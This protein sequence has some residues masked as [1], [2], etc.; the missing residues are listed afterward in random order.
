MSNKIL[1]FK[2]VDGSDIVSEVEGTTKSTFLLINPMLMRSELLVENGVRSVCYLCPWIPV[3]VVK[4]QNIEI[5]KEKVLFYKEVIEEITEIY[6]EFVDEERQRER[7][8]QQQQKI[9]A[10]KREETKDSEDGESRNVIY[11]NSINDTKH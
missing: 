1:Y 11:I 4:E 10:K 8:Y 7:K 5:K 6:I 9:K 2:L 3:G